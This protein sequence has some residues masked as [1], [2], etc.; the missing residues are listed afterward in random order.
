[1]AMADFTN[2]DFSLC[3]YKSLLLFHLHFEIQIKPKILSIKQKKL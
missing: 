2:R 3:F 1:M